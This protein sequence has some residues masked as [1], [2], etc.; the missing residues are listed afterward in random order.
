MG[1]Y[2]NTNTASLT[3]RRNMNQTTRMLGQSFERLSSGLRINSAKDD[4]AGLAI[5]ERMTT[6]IRGINQAVRNTN[7]GISLAQTAEGGLQESTAILQ[8]M[9]ELSVQSANDTNTEADRASIQEEVTALVDELDR[10]A[11]KTTFNNQNILDGSFT[12]AKFHIGANAGESLSISVKD[13]RSSSL[14]RQARYTSS[15]DITTAGAGDAL[16]DGDVVIRGVT[17]RSTVAADDSLSTTLNAA[18]AISKAAAINDS[19]EFTGVS[20][21]VEKTEIVANADIAAVT[22]DS[23]NN[24]SINGVVLTGFRVQDNDADDTLV[25]QINAVSD[26]TG[27]VASLDQDNR[28][29][30]SAEDGRNIELTVLG[31]GTRTGLGGVGT[32]VT[33]GR[34]T[35]QSEDQFDLTGAAISKLGDVGGA[36]ASLFGVNDEFSVSNLDVTTREGANEAIST[37]DVAIGQVSS[38]RSE[39]GAVQNRLSSTVRNLEVSSENLSASRSRIQ[40]ADFASETAVFSKNKIVQQAGVSVLAQANQQPNIALSLLG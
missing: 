36:G 34:L 32:T 14:G 5:S 28:M 20:A 3:A 4:A 2:V 26:E 25:N 6:Q 30:L 12:G 39:L 13:A 11:T 27:V 22:M 16:S 1:L 10:I 38:F 23:T 15:T 7:D 19:T 8:R 24:I 17:I 31:N 40:D 18:S 37:L 33:G 9:R 21:I 35:L 29:V